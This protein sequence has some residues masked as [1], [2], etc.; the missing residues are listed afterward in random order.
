MPDVG[1]AAAF[2][3]A[4]LGLPHFSG[5]RENFS[6]VGNDRGLF[7]LVPVGRVWLFTDR[8]STDAS[9]TGH[10]RGRARRELGIPGS[11]HVIEVASG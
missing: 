9:R 5:D 3:E 1:A 4:E 8:P 2:L 11:A 6:A 7:I 10:D